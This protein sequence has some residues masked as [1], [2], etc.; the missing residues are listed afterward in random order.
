MVS[1]KDYGITSGNYLKNNGNYDVIT[2]NGKPHAKWCE[3]NITFKWN[4]WLLIYFT[5]SW[6]LADCFCSEHQ[7]RIYWKQH[8]ILTFEQRSRT[9][10]LFMLYLHLQPL[11]TDV[12]A[13]E[14]DF[15]FSVIN[16][17]PQHVFPEKLLDLWVS[18]KQRIE[19]H[20]RR[21]SAVE[22]CSLVSANI[23]NNCYI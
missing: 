6:F 15:W 21:G 22:T 9:T 13:L 16:F 3:G 4:Q 14:C 10:I 8:W 18:K 20:Q 2:G 11:S 1:L 5:I 19:R 7:C 12:L 17:W 23:L